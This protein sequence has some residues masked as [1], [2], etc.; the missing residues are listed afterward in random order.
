MRIFTSFALFALLTVQSFGQLPDGIVDTQNPSSAPPSPTESLELITVPEGFHISLFAGEPDVAQPIAIEYDDRGRL[1]VLE[2][3]S[4]IEWKRS[5]KDRLVIFEDTDNDGEFDKR[6][7]FWDQGNH[8]SGFQIG[9]GGV[10]LCD[11][12][13]L[14]FIPDSDRDDVVDGDPTIVLDGWS[15]EAEHNF[16]NGLKWGPDGWLYGRHGIKKPSKVGKPGTPDD[17]RTPLSCSIWRY[18]PSK[19]RFEVWAEGTVNPWGLAWNEEGEGFITTSV[20]DH[21]WHLVPGAR[22]DQGSGKGSGAH[23]Y[24]MMEP[25]SDHRHWSGGQTG[26]K[27]FT[28]N[29]EAGGGHSH[30]GM[31]IYQANAWPDKYRGKV[32]FSNVLGQRLNM[33]HL[34]RKESAWTASHGEDFLRSTSPWFRAVDLCQ[35]PYG[36]M[37]M[38]EWTDLGECHDRDGIHRSSGRLYEVWYGN[39]AEKTPFDVASMSNETLIALLFHEN[40][41]WRHHA[42]RNLHER[43][44]QPNHAAT[45]VSDES[46][47]L[48]LEKA[49][50]AP[51][52]DAISAVQAL[53]ALLPAENWVQ[54]IYDASF[55]SEK[56]APVRT[57]LL[58]LTFTENTPSL[59]QVIWLENIIQKETD[60]AVLYRIAALLQRIPIELRWN[61]AEAL[62]R[63]T[64][65][66]DDR[67]FALMRWYGFEPLVETNPARAMQV[68]L[69][70]GHPWL[71]Q[72]ITKRAVTADSLPAVVTA[73]Q[74]KEIETQA[75]HAMLTGLLEALP[76][77]ADMPA[78]W[79]NLFSILKG[80]KDPEIL[81]QAFQLALRFGDPSGEEEI[82]ERIFAETTP[83]SKRLDYF[84]MLI[85]AESPVIAG[86]LPEALKFPELTLEAI[87]AESVFATEGSASRLLALLSEEETTNEQI[88][89]ILETL[90]SRENFADALVEALFKSDIAKERIPT[91]VA[92][93]IMMTTS[94]KKA[95]T[96]FIGIEEKGASEKAA[97]IA[98]WKK[99]LSENYLA[100][101]DAVDGREVFRRVCSACHQL[102]EE[103]G[104]IG[105]NLT[106]SGRADLDYFL[107]N[108]L[109]PSE[110]VSPDYR[111]VTLTLNNGRTLVGNVVEEND[112]VITFRQVG[113]V[114]RIDTSEVKTR[115]TSN[116]SLMPP[117]LLD[118]LRREDVRDLF[119]YLRTTK[120][121]SK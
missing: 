20:I 112:Q 43:G 70:P 86:K 98:T 88:T 45:L 40:V 15:T 38:A 104:L 52:P 39:R 26:R 62:A 87:R 63:I 55:D 47:K 50:T 2:S 64:I 72:A 92:L 77:R 13:E 12:P 8:T 114:E 94:Q 115:Q 91:Y 84:R 49:K 66:K 100:S 85:S 105:P 108:V 89:A 81:T 58:T 82:A 113:Q 80:K 17:E 68:A 35:G 33:E 54:P 99:R 36:E 103:G 9:H 32:F 4:Y 51:V 14:L 7:I 59:K 73:L 116:V 60:S 19:T 21:F 65:S 34:S 22:Y 96:K 119:L 24:A 29:D 16:F 79:R 120:P 48:L 69:K 106:G 95:F 23:S 44:N 6:T 109:F 76:M 27:D 111:L 61:A 1:W 28:G 83:D 18:H 78:E 101:G 31:M 67:N 25:T 110:D 117:G 30:C 11:A 53:H 41:W 57:H 42:L 74:S 121:L 93:Q 3:F 46:R 90:A 56:R 75:L 5:G 118:S 37:M 71:S 97:Q 107:I 102:Y 10:W